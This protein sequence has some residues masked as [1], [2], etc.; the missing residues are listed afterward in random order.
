[1]VRPWGP[2]CSSHPITYLSKYLGGLVYS[3]VWR[4]DGIDARGN[5]QIRKSR[6]ACAAY[7]TT[8]NWCKKHGGHMHCPRRWGRRSAVTGR[9]RRREGNYLPDLEGL[10]AGNLG[11]WA[12]RCDSLNKMAMNFNR[13]PAEVDDR[14]SASNPFSMPAE[15]AVTAVP[16]LLGPRGE[17]FQ[18]YEAQC[19]KSSFFFIEVQGIRPFTIACCT[20]NERV[21]WEHS[22]PIDSN[23]D[24]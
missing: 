21:T 19:S 12:S 15:I 9:W 10:Q 4:A 3:R 6:P 2:E 13:Y 20:W 11:R 24:D 22:L 7:N 14:F 5:S 17:S 23:V 1:M 16:M 8:V 18:V